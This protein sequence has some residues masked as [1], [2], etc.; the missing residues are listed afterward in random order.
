MIRRDL[1]LPGAH[2]A[3]LSEW[4]ATPH[5]RCV[6]VNAVD[7]G[8]SGRFG[9]KA[10][11]KG[12]MGL[13][14]CGNRFSGGDRYG[15]DGDT[16]QQTLCSAITGAAADLTRRGDQA[17]WSRVRRGVRGGNCSE[18]RL[19]YSWPEFS[20]A[21]PDDCPMIP[22]A[23]LGTGSLRLKLSLNPDPCKSKGPAP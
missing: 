22:P 11:D 6:C 10:V 7:K 19:R 18:G 5:P 8:V 20:I 4:R 17:S 12:L 14:G 2:L 21:V 13:G 3:S 1:R 16:V 15:L 23:D 9:V